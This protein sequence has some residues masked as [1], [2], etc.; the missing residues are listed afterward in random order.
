MKGNIFLIG[1]MGAG[2]ST[3]ARKLQRLYG[4]QL[5]EMDE[6][7]ERQEGM[8]IQEIFA[9]KGEPYFRRLETELLEG[10]QQKE[11]TVVSC[12]GGVPM[13]TCNVEAM[14][15]SGKIVYLDTSAETIYHR[16][17][18]CHHRPLLEGNMNMEYISGLLAERMPK[19][20]AAADV[21]VATDGKKLDKICREIVALCEQE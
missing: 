1:F 6:Q 3:I 21:T 18:D 8:R 17:K 2:K 15:K 10:M 16:V 20:L 13:R 4:M 12:G 5:I 9:Q 19:Y 14:R 11:N 7:I